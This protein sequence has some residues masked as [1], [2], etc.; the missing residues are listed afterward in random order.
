MVFQVRFNYI[1]FTGELFQFIFDVQKLKSDDKIK[2]NFFKDL[3]MRM[4]KKQTYGE[5]YK[6]DWIIEEEKLKDEY[7]R[8][9]TKNAN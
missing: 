3:L 4:Y 9:L 5:S 6:Y 8:S 2:Y 1:N 7:F